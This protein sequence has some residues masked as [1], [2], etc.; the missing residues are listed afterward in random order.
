MFNDNYI[1]SDFIYYKF[2]NQ[3]YEEDIFFLSEAFLRFLND[4]YR[5]YREI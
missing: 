2:E 5:N 4:I 1:F 3:S